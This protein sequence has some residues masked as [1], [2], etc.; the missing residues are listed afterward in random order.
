MYA[1]GGTVATIC[2]QLRPGITVVYAY[3]F[4]II[5]AIVAMPN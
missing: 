2:D 1:H 5:A 4:C 3:D